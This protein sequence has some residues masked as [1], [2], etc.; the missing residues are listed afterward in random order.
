VF[1]NCMQNSEEAAALEQVAERLRSRFPDTPADT[2]N[3][4]VA[5]VH[6]EFDGHPIRDFIPVLVERE[7]VNHLRARPQERVATSA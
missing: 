6:H 2:V 7:A 1:T 4:L 5:E 3:R